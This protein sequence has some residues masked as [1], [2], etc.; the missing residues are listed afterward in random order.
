MPVLPRYLMFYYVR[1]N[2][3]F[4]R[5]WNTIK[6]PVVLV[7]VALLAEITGRLFVDKSF[8]FLFDFSFWDG[9]L[10]T[11]GMFALPAIG[12]ALDKWLRDQGFFIERIFTGFEPPEN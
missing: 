8:V 12:S 6:I 4:F 1:M 7:L 10:V 2:K 3:Y 5:A 11:L 9:F